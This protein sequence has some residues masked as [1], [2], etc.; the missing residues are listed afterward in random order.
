[1][2]GSAGSELAG[3]VCEHRTA[4]RVTGDGREGVS[5]EV[6]RDLSFRGGVELGVPNN[7]TL[8]SPGPLALGGRR[9]WRAEGQWGMRKGQGS[10]LELISVIEADPDS[11]HHPCV[12][13]RLQ[14]VPGDGI[15]HQVEMQWVFPVGGTGEES[16][17]GPE[18]TTWNKP[19][20]KRLGSGNQLCDSAQ[21]FVLFPAPG[22]STPNTWPYL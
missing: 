8:S 19:H 9:G 4:L 21:D 17:E 5:P 12:E 1:M 6:V 15:S 3:R 2:G 22:P 10:C 13:K 18:G 20:P 14:N 16:W 7:A 11:G